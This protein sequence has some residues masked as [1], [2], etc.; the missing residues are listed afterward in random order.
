MNGNS[1]LRFVVLLAVGIGLFS[2]CGNDADSGSQPRPV[3]KGTTADLDGLT[4]FSNPGSV[5]GELVYVPIYSSVFHQS[6]NREYA[7]TSTLSIHNIDLS[8]DLRISAV[9]YF[10]TEGGLVSEYLSDPLIV[11]PLSTRQ[12]TVPEWDETGGTGA[13][14]LVKWESSTAVTRP[15]I[16]AVMITTSGQQGISFTTQGAVVRQLRRP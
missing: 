9:S 1:L 11:G 3:P 14:F 2:G 5:Y 4:T 15:I 12:F 6:A 7:M 16:E 13:N 8:G 10:D